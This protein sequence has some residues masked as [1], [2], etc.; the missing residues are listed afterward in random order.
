MNLVSLYL[1]PILFSGLLLLS[2]V[3]QA[4]ASTPVHIPRATKITLMDPDTEQT[5]PIY[6]KLPRSY[7]SSNDKV[8]PVVYMMDAPYAFQIVS[9]ATRFPMNTNKMDEAILVGIGYA[10]GMGGQSSRIRDFTPLKSSLWRK[11]T[12]RAAKHLAFIESQVINYMEK[13]YRVDPNNR[14]FMGNSLGGL[15]GGYI[16]LTKPELFHNYV[17]GSPSFWFHN[18]YIFK[19]EHELAA[20]RQTVKARVFIGIGE[21][22]T[23]KLDGKYDMVQDAQAFT[24]RLESWQPTGLQ[25]KLMVFPEANHETAFP[26]TA[27]QGLHWLYGR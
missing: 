26:M 7:K 23:A 17:L 24:K 13:H 22:E 16:L 9:G 12:G 15:L 21:R 18:G 2:F 20:K 27:I 1:R 19:L 25:V 3:G 14:T 4:E 11:E 10:R 6:I 8:Y 5:Y